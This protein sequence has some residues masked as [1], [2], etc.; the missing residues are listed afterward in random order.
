MVAEH[1]M[2]VEHGNG[3]GDGS[4]GASG[5][6]AGAGV[7]AGVGCGGTGHTL[8]LSKLGTPLVKA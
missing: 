7:G 4:G 1:V 6:G 8:G 3:N 5:G 2:R